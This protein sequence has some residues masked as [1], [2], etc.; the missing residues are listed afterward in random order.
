MVERNGER[1]GLMNLSIYSS[2]TR[3]WISLG[4]LDESA[5]PG[6]EVVLT[7]GEPNGGSQNPTI[8]RHAQTT[9]RATVIPRPFSGITEGSGY[10]VLANA[11]A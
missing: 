9:V 6:D 1:V 7:W 2:N 5:Q 3:S 10:R 11:S 4:S 8:E